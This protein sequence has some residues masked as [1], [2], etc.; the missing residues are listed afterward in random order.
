MR[1]SWV[2]CKEI[3]RTNLDS[4]GDT[5]TVLMFAIAATNLGET[6]FGHGEAGAQLVV[7]ISEEVIFATEPLDPLDVFL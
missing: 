2:Q 6:A 1:I 4:E 7:S 5:F 3:V